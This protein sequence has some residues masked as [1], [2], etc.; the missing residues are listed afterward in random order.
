MR[1]KEEAQDY[2][3]FPEADIPPVI[4]DEEWIE[5]IRQS[6]PSFLKPKNRYIQEYGYLLMIPVSLLLQGI[7]RIL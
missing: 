3:Y 2:R 6:L 7:V 5:D 1:S 4:I